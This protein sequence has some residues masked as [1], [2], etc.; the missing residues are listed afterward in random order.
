[1]LAFLQP[2]SGRVP[3]RKHKFY[4]DKNLQHAVEF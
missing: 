2:K 3:V 4:R 1:M